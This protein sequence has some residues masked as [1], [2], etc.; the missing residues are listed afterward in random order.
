MI[1]IKDSRIW[2]YSEDVDS[3]LPTLDFSLISAYICP[4]CKSILS[5]Y[6]VGTIN[7]R[8]LEY[9]W[10]N[11]SREYQVGTIKGGSYILQTNHGN[12]SYRGKN[13]IYKT[14]RG[15]GIE[16]SLKVLCGLGSLHN[17]DILNNFVKAI[18]S[19][20][21]KDLGLIAVG[22]MCQADAPMLLYDID[23]I[24]SSGNSEQYEW[25]YEKEEHLGE[26]IKK[27]MVDLYY[28]THSSDRTERQATD[29]MVE[30][31]NPSECVPKYTRL[32]GRRKKIR[33]ART[34]ATLF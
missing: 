14:A 10:R 26:E 1:T 20:E 3:E 23:K 24:C 2:F 16:N 12:D 21:T 32:G 15:R 17:T 18:E 28:S 31:S 5:A 27:L 22:D 30:G 13:C 8:I 7:E 11:T 4:Y 34:Q 9:Y 33:L 19:G 6:F 29:L 25:D